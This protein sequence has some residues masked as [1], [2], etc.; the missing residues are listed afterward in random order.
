MKLHENIEL[1]K[2][3]ITAT[4]QQMGIAEIYVE[5]DYWVTLALY[6]IFSSE[7]GSQAV[8]K[9]GTALSKC[10]KTIDRF[11]ED[12][13]MVILKSGNESGNQLK[14]KIKKISKVVSGV[15]PEIDVPGI[16]NKFGMIRKTA[17]SYQKNFDGQFGQ[18]RDNIILESTWL[19]S[20]EPYTTAMVSSFVTDMMNKTGQS[21]LIA[22]YNLQPFQVQVLSKERTLCEKIMSLVRFSF[23]E[24]PIVDLNNKVRHIY[25]IH[26]LLA[27][28]E[29]KD[30][31]ISE[32]FESMLLTVANDDVI[33]FK[34]NDWLANHPSTALIFSDTNNT[35]NE[36]KNTYLSTFSD[37]VYGEL[38]TEEDILITLSQV[39]ERLKHINWT[40]KK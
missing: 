15:I 33:S 17:H 40:I 8:F 2:D 20:F 10:Y 31:F 14:N 30:F 22:E 19:G 21:A 4:A 13:D 25:D 34:N 37:L 24:N 27:D 18:V 29:M 11:S 12:I 32:R 9:G 39:S 5:K 23:T 36:I 26:K 28:I 3:A 1:Y 38:P 16:T 7:V 6:N 35:W